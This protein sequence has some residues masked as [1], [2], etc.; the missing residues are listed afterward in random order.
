M[1]RTADDPGADRYPSWSPNGDQI[2]F[3]SER[4]GGGYFVMPAVGGTATRLASTPGTN[5]LY[6]SPPGWS[7]DGTQLACVNHDLADSAFDVFLEIVSMVTR[8]TQR[9]SL[10]GTQKARIDL[11]WSRDGAHAA[12]VDLGQQPAETSHSSGCFGCLTG[13]V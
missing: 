12:Y 4:D 8:E 2:A 13:P 3:W 1:N 9:F 6:H 5:D 7:A 10:P 11:S